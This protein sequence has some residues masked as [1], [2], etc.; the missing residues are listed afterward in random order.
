MLH[1]ALRQRT[2]D[3]RPD[4][5]VIDQRIAVGENVTEG[6]DTLGIRDLGGHLWIRFTEVIDRLADNFKM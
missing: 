2:G 6:Y 1:G 3:N 5:G 4:M